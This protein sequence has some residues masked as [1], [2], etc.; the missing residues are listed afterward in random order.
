MPKWV[1][2]I[3]LDK[4]TGCGDCIAACKLENNIAI[5]S[6]EEASEGRV[7][8]ALDGYDYCL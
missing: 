2:V 1:M 8:N 7:I 6:P 4:C 5:V 3:D